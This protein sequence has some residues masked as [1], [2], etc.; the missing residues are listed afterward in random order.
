MNSASL[1]F[2]VWAVT[3][4]V[5]GSWIA[6]LCWSVASR[7]L[8]LA[9]S[10]QLIVAETIFGLGYGFVFER[11]WPAAAELTG[12]VL[13]LTGVAIAVGI[14][15]SAGDRRTSKRAILSLLRKRKGS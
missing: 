6:T 10:A 4:G 2:L 1:N 8:P 11:R 15:A 3:L 7:R 12:A 9:L 5:A 14:F 13:Q